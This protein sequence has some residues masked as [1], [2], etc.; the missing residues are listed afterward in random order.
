MTLAASALVWP[1]PSDDDQTSWYSLRLVSLVLSQG[2]EDTAFPPEQISLPFQFSYLTSGQIGAVRVHPDESMDMEN[3][4]KSIAESLQTSTVMLNS[5]GL[6]VSDA[7]VVETG[8]NGVRQVLYTEENNNG[9][10]ALLRGVYSQNMF[11]SVPAGSNMD[12]FPFKLSSSKDTL[13]N[14][15]DSSVVSSIATTKILA[16]H[17]HHSSGRGAASAAGAIEVTTTTEMTFSTGEVSVIDMIDEVAWEV[18][19]LIH[20]LNPNS[21]LENLKARLPSAQAL[22]ASLRDASLPIKEA[23]R[24]RGYLVTL[25]NADAASLEA[26]LVALAADVATAQK[27]QLPLLY[28][29]LAMIN[30][31]SA[32]GLLASELSLASEAKDTF[33]VQVILKSLAAL[34]RPAE[35]ATLVAPVRA[36]EAASSA[37]IRALAELTVGHLAKLLPAQEATALLAQYVE[38]LKAATTEGDKIQYLHVLGNAGVNAP[39]SLITPFLRD[40][41]LQVRAAALTNLRAAM[42]LSEVQEA[43]MT[44][45]QH[46]ANRQTRSIISSLVTAV[47]HASQANDLG[48]QFKDF[49]VNLAQSEPATSEAMSTLNEYVAQG[50]LAR[51]EAPEAPHGF[52]HREPKVLSSTQIWNDTSDSNY[53]LVAPAAQR[54]QD[55]SRYS[56]YT[57][58]LFSQQIGPRFTNLK[59]AGGVFSGSG[60]SGCLAGDFKI[61]DKLYTDTHVFG[62]TS[63][64]AD[65]QLYILTYQNTFDSRVYAIVNGNTLLDFSIANNCSSD[66]LIIFE[67][68]ISILDIT[69]EIPI[70]LGNLEVYAYVF[71]GLS[72]DAGYELCLLTLNPLVELWITGQIDLTVDAGATLTALGV[73][74][75]GLE[76]DLYV[77][78]L[79]GPDT[80]LGSIVNATTGD[81]ECKACIGVYYGTEDQIGYVGLF[82]QRR[83]GLGWGDKTVIP[84]VDWVEPGV[85]FPTPL[86]ETCSDP[87]AE[88][89]VLRN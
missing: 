55:V 18:E 38:Q 57:A 62:N 48:E 83:E 77:N 87:A 67:G 30:A 36:A 72:L 71:A 56:A 27:S 16:R 24:L 8:A 20:E 7:L 85:P 3:I 4:K 6:D 82:I 5:R 28:S 9:A 19:S 42:H 37:Q 44:M 46:Q 11:V 39:I 74:R 40:G 60:D 50:G 52:R 29:T 12:K 31:R 70:D 13:V 73:I 41:S 61:F 89:R 32:Q 86:I 81:L 64:L 21:R 68:V 66:V 49:L 51:P 54:Q 22:V 58:Y 63:V 10:Q 84:I 45:M 76:G 17:S 75:G 53:N 23:L 69:T 14:V 1:A 34:A 88:L 65:L 25:M 47:K 26:G 43:V 2:G 33:R 79:I 78:Y 35:P 80:Q 59:I 15:A